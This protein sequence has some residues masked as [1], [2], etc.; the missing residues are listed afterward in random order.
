MDFGTVI[1]K[2]VFSLVE[3]LESLENGRIHLCFPQSGGSLESLEMDFSEKTSFRK[4]TFFRTR[5]CTC[6][7]SVTERHFHGPNHS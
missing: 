5:F 1:M 7:I 4:D 3:S 2:R 6:K